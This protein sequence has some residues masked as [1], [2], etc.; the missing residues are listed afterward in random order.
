MSIPTPAIPTATTASSR[1]TLLVSMIR[2][3]PKT[4]ISMQ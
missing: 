2:P 1:I 4:K 3:R